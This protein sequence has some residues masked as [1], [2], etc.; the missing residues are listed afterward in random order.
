MSKKA[1]LEPDL[2]PLYSRIKTLCFQ[3]RAFWRVNILKA[4]TSATT[5]ES[6]TRWLDI[7]VLNEWYIQCIFRTYLEHIQY[8]LSTYSVYY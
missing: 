4:H 5:D 3:M 7:L 1:N 8:I 2:S 6:G